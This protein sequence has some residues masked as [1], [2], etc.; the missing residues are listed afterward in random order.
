MWNGLSGIALSTMSGR[1]VELF[2]A[3]ARDGRRPHKKLL[4]RKKTSSSSE[5]LHRDFSLEWRR[6]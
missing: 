6:I 1:G 5:G 2:V 3:I 4:R